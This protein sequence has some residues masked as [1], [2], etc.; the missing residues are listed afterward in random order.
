METGEIAFKIPVLSHLRKQKHCLCFHKS[1]AVTWAKSG[2]VQGL[3]DGLV[4]KGAY[5]SDV[6]TCI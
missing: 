4:D 6:R 3:G 5:G 1:M 2:R